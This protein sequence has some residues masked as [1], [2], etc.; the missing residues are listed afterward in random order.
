M[1][2]FFVINSYV[3]EVFFRYSNLCVIECS[4]A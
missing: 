4:A 1:Y 2:G 3:I